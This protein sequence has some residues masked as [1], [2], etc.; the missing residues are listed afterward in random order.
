MFPSRCLDCNK[1]NYSS[2]ATTPPRECTCGSVNYFP[3][4]IIHLIIPNTPPETPVFTSQPF[5]N[6]EITF[7]GGQS[8]NIAC[9][10]KTLP[11]HCTEQPEGITCQKC[12]EYA[13]EVL[14]AAGW[15]FSQESASQEEEEEDQ[16]LQ[17]MEIEIHLEEDPP[18]PYV[19][20]NQ[21]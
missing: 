21:H 1:I 7:K 10:L 19:T 6:K 11:P 2:K 3:L 4:A 15:D 9:G 5:S 14:G 20:D 12:R 8:W 13:E 17:N 18:N 16:N